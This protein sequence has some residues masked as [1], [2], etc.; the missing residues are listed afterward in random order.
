M[1]KIYMKAQNMYMY[2]L[3][4]F[5]HVHAHTQCYKFNELQENKNTHNLSSGVESHH[6]DKRSDLH[7]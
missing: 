2:I 7:R 6:A 4:V 3:H 1:F 5:I